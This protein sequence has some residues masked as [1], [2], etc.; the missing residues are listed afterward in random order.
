MKWWSW[1]HGRLLAETLIKVLGKPKDGT[2]AF[3]R[4]LTPDMV[5]LLTHDDDNFHLS[6]WQVYRVSISG[7]GPRTITPGHAVELRERKGPPVLL[8][9]DTARIG[10]GMDGIFNAALEV[11]EHGLLQA[12]QRCA[13]REITK[14][15]SRRHREYAEKAVG[16]ARG[17]GGRTSVPSW[18]VYDFYCRVVANKRHAGAYLHLLG[19]W[20]VAGKIGRESDAELDKSQRLVAHFFG[21]SASGL[22][23]RERIEAAR[24]LD[25]TDQQL[26]DLERFIRNAG[27]QP[28]QDALAELAAKRNLW[29]NNL[30]LE[31]AST[32][33]RSIELMPWRGSTGRLL[34]WSGLVD[35][36]D[37]DEPP[38]L[39]VDPDPDQ[40]KSKLE[41]RW[42][43]R[44]ADVPK[45]AAHYRVS[46]LTT[47]G[48][49]ELTSQE[50][51]HRKAAQQ[52]WVFGGGDFS[53]LPEDAKVRARIR[54]A[55][56]G[57]ESDDG[58]EQATEDEAGDP[59]GRMTVAETEEFEITFG[60]PIA[61]E[62]AAGGK[63]CRTFAEGLIELG[64]P[65]EVALLT[66][67]D[68]SRPKNAKGAFLTWRSPSKRMS[69]RVHRPPLIKEVEDHW[70]ISGDVI[71]RWRVKVRSSGERVGKPTFV[72]FYCP[73][74]VTK[75]DWARMQGACKK[76]I[77]RFGD[78]GGVGQV[79]DDEATHG[80]QVVKEYLRAW[81]A[82]LYNDA[83]PQ[84]ALG[85]TVEVQSQ[86]G[87]LIGLIVLP[88]HPLR[89]A[90]HVAYDNLVLHAAFAD[91]LAPKNIRDEFKVLDGAMFPAMLPGVA[92]AGSTGPD[93]YTFVFA[94]TLGFHA[95]GMVPDTDKEPKATVAVLC[96]ALGDKEDAK[97]GSVP[98]VGTRSADILGGEVLKYVECHGA[99]RTLHVHALR[100]GDGRTVARA[101]GKASTA[102]DEMAKDGVAD[103]P[104]DDADE[105]DDTARLA[106]VLELYPSARSRD[107]GVVGRFISECQEKRRR[108]AGTTHKD[109]LWLLES[110]TL[111]GGISVPRLRWARK[112]H[113]EPTQP[114]HLA[115]AF[116]T[117][118]SNVE[119]DDA[120]ARRRP[121]HAFGLLSFFDR[122]YQGA[123]EPNWRSAVPTWKEGD[124][125]PGDRTHT[126]RLM[127]L[128]N[129]IQQL[130]VRSLDIGEGTP[131]LRTRISEDKEDSLASL[132][133]L[134]DW[135][136]TLD[137]NAGI[138]YFDSPND[139]RKIYDA[140]VIDCVPERE[141]LG[142]LQL[143]TSTTNKDEVQALLDRALDGMGLS[144]SPRN[145]DFLM[146]QLKALSG[147]LAIR[148]TGRKVPASE[149]IALAL[150]QANCAAIASGPTR[151]SGP[152]S[153]SGRH[154]WTPLRDGFFVPVDDVRDLLPPLGSEAE[155]RRGTPRPDLI[156][157]TSSPREGLLFRFV[158]VKYRRHLR[159]ARSPELL[160][161]IRHQT[162]SLRQR[163]FLWYGHEVAPSFRAVRRA[164]LARVLRFYADKAHRHDLTSES[165]Q[166][167]VAEIDRVVRKGGAYAFA[168]DP[169]SVPDLGWVFCPDHQDTEPQ[170]LSPSD[171]EVHVYL[172][173]PGGLPDLDSRYR[174]RE[175]PEPVPEAPTKPQRALILP[176]APELA[177]SPPPTSES[178]LPTS[179]PPYQT[180][181]TLPPKPTPL[182]AELATED[183]GRR[184]L[185]ESAVVLGTD[186]YAQ[187]Q[188]QWQLTVKG[189][190]HLLVAGLPGMG[191]TT[192]LLN[193]CRQMLDAGVRPIV[194]SY[195]QDL[196]E[197]LD[198]MVG[199]IR[200]IDFIGLGFNPL[201][202]PDRRA[203]RPYLE[204]AGMMR[205]IFTAIYS[206][207]GDL[208]A[209][210]VRGA[211]K[212]SF[213]EA[214]WAEPGADMAELVEP[215]FKRFYEI[216]AEQEKPDR[217]LANLLTRLEE[218]N[219][220][221]LFDIG[222]VHGSLWEGSKPTVIRI[223]RTQSDVLQNAF[224]SLVLYGLYKDMFR[225]GIQDRVTHA[226]IFDEA[227]RAARLNVIP[228]MAKECRKYGV[229]LVLAS[230][231]ARDFHKSVFSAI[232][233]YLVL[234]LTDAD[235]KTLVRNVADSRQ[236][237]ALID[238]I[239]QMK[240]FRALYFQEGKTRPNH[241]D[242]LN[243]TDP[244]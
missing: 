29:V 149:L 10:A 131:V 191:K 201:Q 97:G 47:I 101:L 145:A 211:V 125:H 51:L 117:F 195:H 177:P 221:G 158:E 151:S 32:A 60:E 64:S 204:V 215:P 198:S 110:L 55:A 88:S 202:I 80:F 53:T 173:G 92:P 121:F 109:D 217:G 137:R 25:P 197:K 228:T 61:T 45:G 152:A 95:V 169:G 220:Y 13:A 67:V 224:S 74:G 69:F 48:D 240:R 226:V 156:Y 21:P 222:Q 237:K 126:D 184:P 15:V 135:V 162:A 112:D 3:I 161:R 231:E 178:P 199:S 11:P 16:R 24:L 2:V 90:W 42:K 183:D 68:G 113:S 56:I 7:E 37:S 4:C 122:Q 170:L 75:K 153:T 227:H 40:D 84:L 103:A 181:P 218:L 79:Y 22:M 134:C 107:A 232:A 104:S 30:N 94:D 23:P 214:G 81:T 200:F 65:S 205:D 167:L 77:A 146:E 148:L 150:V 19:L 239:K 235:A 120:Q 136:V 38:R 76:M 165:H 58:P 203:H 46:V 188:V 230:Q 26:A 164:K 166:A 27:A 186:R 243:Y 41:V 116:D 14:Q 52:R 99:C 17:V 72:P 73:N 96:R 242:L 18:T 105:S 206:G 163:W 130:V 147:R 143:I 108:R 144:R 66:A 78:W 100:A 216:L 118:E 93:P 128:Q 9:V 213:V 229:S 8:L 115:I 62:A 171:S 82:M 114:A 236:E 172:F 142:C 20:P 31:D 182:P 193:L 179:A 207:L 192:C 187:A 87:R 175:P 102:V 124:K 71:G 49:E 6:G 12:A 196:D 174:R 39:V 160:D 241:V 43:T 194:F 244:V 127:R 157:V 57:A 119:A 28:R 185:R 132:H 159:T 180:A 54:V 140:Y 36:I 70:R 176:R 89:M 85:N 59:G 223:H 138:E 168:D 233:N 63:V 154:C 129:H 238:Q 210:A 209:E 50:V 111:P 234:R 98:Q 139:N 5:D 219:D 208:Q 44:P 123:P 133:K 91:D 190:P 225:R 141:D 1:A 35:P 106:F 86:S 189:N 212:D 83:D 33:L 34:K 155:P